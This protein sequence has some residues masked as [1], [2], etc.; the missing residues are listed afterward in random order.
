VG[1]L[2]P[3]PLPVAGRT[4]DEVAKEPRTVDYATAGVHRAD[5][6]TGELLEPGMRFRGPAIVETRGTIVVVRPGDDAAVDAY[7]NL[8]VTLVRE[9][10]SG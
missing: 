5:V 9:E 4:L 3:Q 2:A 10:G 1:K 6:Y 8:V 7:G